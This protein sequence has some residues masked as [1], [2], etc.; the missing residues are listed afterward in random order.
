MKGSKTGKIIFIMITAAV[1]A[2]VFIMAET[3]LVFPPAY[4]KPVGNKVIDDGNGHT[5]RMDGRAVTV[6]L[7]DEVIWELPSDVLAQDV[8]FDDIDRDD[9]CDLLI[10]CWKRGRYGKQRP[11]WVK[12]DEIKWSQ[13]IFVYDVT[14]DKVAPKWM[15]SEIGVH[16]A[17]MECEKDTLYITDTQGEVSEWKWISWG[18]EKL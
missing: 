3:D 2:V 4:S 12:H 5:A 8:F 14:N 11:T 16:A 7:D 10:L 9:R 1:A 13:H 15:A 17:S 6:F 18:F